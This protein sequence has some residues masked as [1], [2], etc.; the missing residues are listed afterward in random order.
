[1]PAGSCNT[2]LNNMDI[3]VRP[4]KSCDHRQKELKFPLTALFEYEDIS[5]FV[6]RNGLVGGG[7][8]LG[9]L[10]TAPTDWPIVACPG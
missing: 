9:P 5:T 7:V 4:T 3:M 6:Y 2:G 1:M 8:E 10:G